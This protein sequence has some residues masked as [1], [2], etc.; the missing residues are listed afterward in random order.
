MIRK[1]AF[2]ILLLLIAGCGPPKNPVWHHPEK[3]L[4]QAEE[5]MENCYF[6]AFLARRQNPVPEKFSK[7][8]KDPRED[9]ESA[10]C[11]CMKEGGY[12]QIAAAKI[13]APLRIKSGIAHTMPYAIAGE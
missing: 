13:E 6:D 9:I 3:T 11:E 12:L 5:D 10:A 4:E 2:T 7:V 1:S 8:E